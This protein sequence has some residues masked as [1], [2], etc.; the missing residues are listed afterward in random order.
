ML[1]QLLDRSTRLASLGKGSQ[2]LWELYHHVEGEGFAS[3]VVGPQDITDRERRAV[4]WAIDRL[5]GDRRY[6]DKFPRNC[7]RAEYLR[8][9]FPS[10]WFVSIVR[11]GRAAV[12][13]L[14]TGWQTDAKFGRGTILPAGLSIDGYT[15]T[16]WKF[17]APP[18]WEEFARGHTLAE[19]CA[20]Q[21]TRANQAIL[22]ARERLGP[23]RWVE[24]RYED[25]VASPREAAAGLLAALGL[26][27][28]PRVLGWAD[29]LDR[30][31]TR[32]AVTAPRTGKWRDEHPDE[33][34]SVMPMLAP[35]LERLGY[36]IDPVRST[37]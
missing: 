25:V 6:L 13:S 18:G 9:M 7:L 12:S 31:V 8:A 27:A 21:W 28:E 36:E 37:G 17:L 11:D 30:H 29:D 22:D 19:V 3:H 14:I 35:T 20:F 16:N 2:F 5:S 26:P 33:I 23:E 10:A 15:G 1:F 34:A 32:T 24:V 4:Y